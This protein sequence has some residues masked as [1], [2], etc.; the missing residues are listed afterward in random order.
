MAPEEHRLVDVFPEGLEKRLTAP[1]GLGR[2][3]ISTGSKTITGRGDI[4]CR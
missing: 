3:I 1:G 2:L 4:T